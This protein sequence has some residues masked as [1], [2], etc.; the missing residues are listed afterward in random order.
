MPRLR[1]CLTIALLAILPAV[2]QTSPP[3]Q[4]ELNGF[5]LGQS[6]KAPDKQFGEPTQV[7]K[8]DDHWTY[9]AYLFDKTTGAY[10]AFKFPPSEREGMVSIQIAGDPGT[11]MTPFLGLVLG[12]DKLKVQHLLGSPEKVEHD[13]QYDV[14]LCTYADRNYSVEINSKGKL[15]SVQIMGFAG[16]ADRADSVMPD[17]N[18]FREFVINH[19]VDRLLTVLAGD[20][21]IYRGEHTY[22]FARS[23]RA[24]LEDQNSDIN[25]LFFGEK[26]SLRAAFTTEKFEPDP[27]IR[28]Y[29]KALPGSVVKFEH[30]KIVREVVYKMQAGAWKVWEITLR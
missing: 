29:E 16:F 22:D 1:L 9:R 17:I 25:R 6:A 21:E 13:K 4:V 2:A 15:S 19:D 20:L 27:Q 24:E 8:T 30:S 28:L 3:S 11:Q 7:M 14:D 26:D 12:D 5:I 18:G 23:A 10:M